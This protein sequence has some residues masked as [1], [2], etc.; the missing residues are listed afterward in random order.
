MDPWIRRAAVAVALTAGLTVASCSGTPSVGSLRCIHGETQS[1]LCGAKAVGVQICGGSGS[2]LACICAE[3]K[4]SGTGQGKKGSDGGSDKDGPANGETKDGQAKDGQA[5]DGASNDVEVD[6]DAELDDAEEIDA[7]PPKDGQ[8][9]DGEGETKDGQAKDGTATSDAQASD[10]K[11][12]VDSGNEDAGSCVATVSAGAIVLSAGYL[13]AGTVGS[14][15]AYAFSDASYPDGSGGSSACVDQTTLCGM[16]FSA[17]I[18]ELHPENPYGGAI[19]VTINQAE[20]INT[21]QGT[22]VPTGTG[23]AYT[24]I[25]NGTHDTLRLQIDNNGTEYCANVGELS[26][27]VPWSA[28]NTTCYSSSTGVYLAGAPV[29]SH[30]EFEVYSTTVPQNWDFCV[31]RLGFAQ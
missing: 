23:I 18:N 24:I 11:A 13:A 20:G 5:K 30:I 12:T 2:Y 27:T 8:A 26:G 29:A 19:G 28:F 6:D 21:T 25:S 1:C 17:E 15:Y 7:P 9:K 16:G 10:A 14:G 4:D 22:L 3:S 31:T